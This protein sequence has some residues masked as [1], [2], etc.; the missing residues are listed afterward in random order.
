M[1]AIK[2][3]RTGGPEVL[4]LIEL[5]V[6]QANGNEAVMKIRA[7]GIN[8]IDIYFREGRYKAVVPFVPGQEAAGEVVAIGPDVT[9]VKVGDRV[10]YC[11]VMGSYAEYSAVPADRLIR[12]P[13]GVS[14]QQSAAAMLQGMTAHYLSHSTFPLQKGQTALVHAAAGGVGLLLVQMAHHI[15]A[16]VIG[17]VSTEEKAR[18]ARDAGAD[19]IIQYTTS[20]FETETRKL[21]DGKGVDVIYDSVGKTT[22]EKGLNVLKARG[23]MVLFGGSSGAV[24]P[25]DLIQ[26]SQKGSLY[27]TRPTLVHYIATRE[28]LELRS[29][30]V[31]GMI[32][33]GTLK[34]RIE[35]TYP[36]GKA[37]QA[38][39]DLESR[40]TTGKLLLL[41]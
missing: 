27:V 10:A 1:K 25:F 3:S 36:L 16:R 29:Q 34:L 6:P 26:L 38:H 28:E 9:A 11:G 12:V 14:F 37:A 19:E 13:E 22:F 39:R 33:A 5:P 20:D 35:H 8:F 15:G 24:P 21:T 23:Y 31:F 30:A 40:K 7:S 4:E 32:K 18:L 17:T 41:N 2:V